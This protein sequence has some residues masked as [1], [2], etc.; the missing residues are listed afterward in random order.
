MILVNKVF[1]CLK[2][3]GVDKDK[4]R[5]IWVDENHSIVYF[6]KMD[7]K[8]SMPRFAQ[9]KIF[10][11]EINNG[12][13]KE[14][15][16]PFKKFIDEER[17][18]EK[19]KVIR[20]ESWEIVD[21]I[22]NQ[23]QKEI[24]SR[25]G[26]RKYINETANKFNVDTKRIIRFLCRFWNRGMTKNALLPD[27]HKSGAKGKDRRSSENKR[28]RPRNYISASSAY[29]GINI[30]KVTKDN[31]TLA[32]NLFYLNKERKSL[33]ETYYLMLEKFFSDQYFED[34]RLI[35][36][37]WDKDKIPT[38]PQF[39]YWCR[40]LSNY[41]K[42]YISRMGRNDFDRKMRELLGNSMIETFGPGSRYQIDATV[43]DIY[44]KSMLNDNIVGR[45]VVYVVIDVFS[46]LVAGI[47]VG[48]EGPSWIGAM[49]ALDNVVEDKVKFC[50]AYGIDI[51]EDEW[52]NSLL[53]ETIIADRGEFEGYNVNNLINN[54]NIRVENT[55][56]YRGDLK[57][58]VERYFRT[59]NEK[60]KHSTPGA[61]QKEFRERGDRDYR[62][63]A[64][65]NIQEF[66][67]IVLYQVIQHNN[68]LLDRYPRERGLI[69]D[70]VD[71]MPTHIWKWG[72]KNRHY[73]SISRDRD[74]LRLN[75]LPKESAS[76]A[77]EGIKFKKMFYSCE[78][79]LCEQW[80]VSLSKRSVD[81]VYDPR[82][83]NYIY[84]LNED[85]TGF[86][87]CYLLEKSQMYRDLPLNEVIFQHEIEAEQN[88]VNKNKQIENKI[89]YDQ[90]IDEIIKSAVSKPD[91]SSQ[92]N[93][94][95]LKNI[96]ENRTKEKDLIRKEESFERDKADTTDEAIIVNMKSHIAGG[97]SETN[98]LKKSKLGLLREM[99]DKH[100]GK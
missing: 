9:F 63:D 2:E 91:K 98:N 71:S 94:S 11:N 53:P 38:Y 99:R 36:K 3:S 29:Q 23:P 81:I 30:D 95:R 18:P 57:G 100:L 26:R 59:V 49:M 76:I 13:I 85:G 52:P 1:E 65:L 82:N 72:I 33:K 14:I 34:G 47:Y 40:K 87:K 22:W 80:F 41:K 88:E 56:P 68:S 16:D 89:V 32:Y 73:A 39:Y 51:T 43:A 69:V 6:V 86:I 44:L 10:E 54:L 12:F 8:S 50:A 64:K 77:R 84:I 67:K 20:D 17:L 21:F 31:F 90:K 66:T 83:V 19:Y 55:A 5:V 78:Q 46:R 79:A 37:I 61:I 45:P 96:R 25:E 7:S 74:V 70:E 27:Y 60:I 92:S 58:I 97:N 75:L 42:D 48:F 15:D 35:S 93:R 28:G 24:L 4:I 62:L